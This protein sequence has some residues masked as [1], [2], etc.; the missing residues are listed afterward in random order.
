M[1]FQHVGE[2]TDELVQKTEGLFSEIM[3]TDEL[4]TERKVHMLSAA[5][6]SEL[7][8]YCVKVEARL[9]ELEHA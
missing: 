7:L 6:I 5:V 1:N 3:P 8:A 4:R 2:M 9:K